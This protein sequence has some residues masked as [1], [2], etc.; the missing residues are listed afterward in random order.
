MSDPGM[1]DP[2]DDD[3][4]HAARQAK[5]AK[6]ATL[7]PGEEVCLGFLEDNEY[8]Q[9]PVPRKYL[10]GVHSV[11]EKT[12][13]KIPKDSVLIERLNDL[14]ER[15]VKGLKKSFTSFSGDTVY[16]LGGSEPDND[17]DAVQKNVW[18]DNGHKKR[19]QLCKVLS[20]L[21]KYFPQECD[22]SDMENPEL[23]NP[24][25]DN[26]NN[27]LKGD[28]K[29]HPWKYLYIECDFPGSSDEDEDKSGGIP[30]ESFVMNNLVDDMTGVLQKVADKS[31]E[32][33]EADMACIK[34]DIDILD[35]FQKWAAPLSSPK[36]IEDLNASVEAVKK[37]LQ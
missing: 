19:F 6:M 34:N 5:R 12:L 29:E 31:L 1:S 36:K 9:E 24:E 23:T 3:V 22:E 35:D 4:A 27:A 13:P 37:V 11:V 15:S 21:I 28:Y 7:S 8:H 10:E 17:M 20:V 18:L 2:D 16:F 32:M 26:T 33:T 14:R 30:T 25:D